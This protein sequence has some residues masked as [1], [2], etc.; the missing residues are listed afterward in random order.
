MPEHYWRDKDPSA[1]TLVPPLNSGPYEITAFKQGRFVEY[2][3]DPDYWGKD[4]PINRGRYNFDTIRFDIYR[5]A[6]VAREAF[7]K[8]L[9]DIW[10]ESDGRYWHGAFDTP[11]YHKGWV[12]KIRLNQG[13]WVGIRQGIVLN[14]EICRS[15]GSAGADPGG[16][17]RVAEQSVAFRVSQRGHTAIGLTR[18]CPRPDCRATMNWPCS[19]PTA[20]SC[21]RSYSCGRF[22]SP[23]S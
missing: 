8:G 3:R 12:K 9:I 18:Y 14:R 17:F 2:R 1:P 6:T 22:A 11:A 10:T 19:P 23:R 20:S 16:G 21:R 13:L 5:D 7:R 4:I 15:T